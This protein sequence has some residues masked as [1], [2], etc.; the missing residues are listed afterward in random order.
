MHLGGA[1]RWPASDE[2][3][4]ASRN[5]LAAAM[6][7]AAGSAPSYSCSMAAGHRWS[8]HFW[9]GQ[10]AAKERLRGSSVKFRGSE[11][12]MLQPYPTHHATH[13]TAHVLQMPSTHLLHAQQHALVL[14]RRAEVAP[15]MTASRCSGRRMRSSGVAVHASG[16]ATDRASWQE[17]QHASL[18]AHRPR[19]PR[20]AR[21]LRPAARTPTAATP[22]RRLP[23][24]ENHGQFHVSLHITLGRK[25]VTLMTRECVEIEPCCAGCEQLPCQMAHLV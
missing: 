4:A 14:A 5:R 15:C 8:L 22:R 7:D 18:R 12:H 25:S 13:V 19:C 24:T 10:R 21:P 11:R 3:R 17:V 9:A 16:H 23:A 1:Y 20:I 6:E 2:E